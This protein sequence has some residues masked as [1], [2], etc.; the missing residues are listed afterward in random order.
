M[1]ISSLHDLLWSVLCCH[2]FWV[3]KRIPKSG[4]SCESSHWYMLATNPKLKMCCDLT[5][6]LKTLCESNQTYLWVTS[7]PQGMC[8]WTTQDRM[9][10]GLADGHQLQNRFCYSAAMCLWVSHTISPI[11]S[12]V[13]QGSQHSP[14]WVLMRIEIIFVR[15]LT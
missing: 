6:V 1:S 7:S 11:S 14:R 10:G 12:S 15:W 5:N 4:F 8:L 13:K 3:F 2:N 9:C